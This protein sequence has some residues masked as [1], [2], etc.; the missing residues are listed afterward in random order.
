MTNVVAINCI[1]PIFSFKI[2]KDKINPHI[3]EDEN[4]TIVFKV[5]IILNDSMKKNKDKRIILIWCTIIIGF[6]FR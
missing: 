6:K 3:V 5:P 2:K 4:M 1:I